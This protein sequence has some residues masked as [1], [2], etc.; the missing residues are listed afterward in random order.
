MYIVSFWIVCHPYI[1]HCAGMWHGVLQGVV[2]S[3]TRLPTN[4]VVRVGAD[5]SLVQPDMDSA[6]ARPLSEVRDLFAGIFPSE[7]LS[8]LDLLGGIL[9]S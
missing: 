8:V 1:D 5:G 9:L 6:S 3:T 7:S 4:T 2:L